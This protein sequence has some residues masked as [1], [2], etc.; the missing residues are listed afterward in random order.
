[1]SKIIAYKVDGNLVTTEFLPK[2]DVQP[3][4]IIQPPYVLTEEEQNSILDK[5]IQ[6]L[7]AALT[8]EQKTTIIEGLPKIQTEAVVEGEEPEP[9]EELP[10]AYNDDDFDRAAT[11]FV[12]NEALE[13][14]ETEFQEVSKAKTP[15]PKKQPVI[16]AETVEE[17]AAK[18]VPKDVEFIIVDPSDLPDGERDLWTIVD[19]KIVIG[20]LPMETLIAGV[21]AQVT[22]RIG[23]K[24]S[25]NTIMNMTAASVLGFPDE[26]GKQRPELMPVFGQALAWVTEVRMTGKQLIESGV[27][28][29]ADDK[30]WP[31]PSQAVQD[32]A[33]EF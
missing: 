27:Q 25:A 15:K 29:F 4:D 10:Q 26:T 9:A 23:K 24:A 33:A 20:S 14:A 17:H 12:Y 22:Q 18:V 6:E 11:E 1:M 32:L 30:H 7:I 13:K 2:E 21:R 8:N 16:K 5:H 19:G 28:D 31:E 3:A